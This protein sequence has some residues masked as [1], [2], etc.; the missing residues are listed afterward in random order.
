[1][2]TEILNKVKD[3]KEDLLWSPAPESCSY[4]RCRVSITLYQIRYDD[5]NAAEGTSDVVVALGSLRL[6]LQSVFLT[7][8][9]FH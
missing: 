3:H 9:Q 6:H 7:C 1:M 8:A 4:F 5:E 2:K